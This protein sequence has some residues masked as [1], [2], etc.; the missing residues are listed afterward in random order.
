MDILLGCL[1]AIIA[2]TWSVQHL[3]MPE[4]R[5]GW[6]LGWLGDIKCAWTSLK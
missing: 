1:F 4:Q 5:E 6:D 3:N 2:C